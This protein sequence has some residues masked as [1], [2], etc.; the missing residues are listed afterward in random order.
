MNEKVSV[1]CNC[2]R[3]HS[4]RRGWAFSRVC[5]SVCLSVHLFAGTLTGKLIELSTPN[6]AYVCNIAVARHALT[7]RSKGQKS[8]SHGDENRHGRTVASDHGRYSVTLCYL[9]PLPAW[10]S[11][12]VQDHM[13]SRALSVW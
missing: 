13:Q 4:H 11:M 7:Q 5:L 9:R 10:I 3:R 8:R 1:A 12:S 2:P 6:L